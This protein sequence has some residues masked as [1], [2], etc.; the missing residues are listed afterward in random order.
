LD[1][2]DRLKKLQEFEKFIST[3]QEEEKLKLFDTVLKKP[4]SASTKK[5]EL[6]ILKHKNLSDSKKLEA[7]QNL[8]A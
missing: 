1:E 7:M 5:D 4:S 8:Y 2:E 6:D 3:L